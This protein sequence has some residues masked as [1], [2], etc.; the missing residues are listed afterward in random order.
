MHAVM[1]FVLVALAGCATTSAVPD[2][3]VGTKGA[4]CSSIAQQHAESRPP[5]D[6][7]RSWVRS[8]DPEV[9]L[10]AYQLYCMKDTPL[11]L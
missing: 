9:A 10:S 1:V 4:P 3:A 6:A 7:E 2:L 11:G 8:I 5:A